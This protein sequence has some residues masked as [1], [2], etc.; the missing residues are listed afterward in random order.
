MS[1]MHGRVLCLDPPTHWSHNDKIGSAPDLLRIENLRVP[2]SGG[3]PD[4]L[5]KS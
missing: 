2:R 3:Q 4:H 5:I 1:L